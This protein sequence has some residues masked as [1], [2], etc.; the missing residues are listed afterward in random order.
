MTSSVAICTYNGE[1]YLKKQIDSILS[2]T[3]NVHEI[4]I[5]DDGSTD[6]TVSIL[7]AYKEKYPGL[8]KIFINKSNLGSVKNFEKA[9]TLCENEII[10]LSDQDDL[11]VSSK[12]EKIFKTFNE[13]KDIAV[14]FTNGHGMDDH[15]R[16]M[17]VFTVWDTINF[18]RN[19][20]YRFD[21]FNILNLRD[22]FCTGATM[23]MRSE[24]K[25][26]LFPIPILEGLHH[27]KWIAMIASLKNK[28]YF[29]DEK[30]IYY[31]EH[32]DQQVA[33]VLYTNKKEEKFS[34]TNYFCIDKENKEFKD[35][36]K[37]LKSF[38]QAYKRNLILS[39]KFPAHQIYFKGVLKE[40][41]KRFKNNKL[42]LNRKFPFRGKLLILADFFTNRRR[43]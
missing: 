14:I 39:E 36:K 16:L 11:W 6:L 19:R 43:I 27:D 30:L 9:L 3:V 4:V 34:V 23:A 13:N 40:L 22:N 32:A 1:K 26:E 7:N 33:N 21:Y 10:F 41:K 2:Q 8:F 12:V 24:I 5:C 20:G 29:L 25:K 28:L 17:D 31:R 18:V 35:Y 37:I 42:E 15:D 38:A